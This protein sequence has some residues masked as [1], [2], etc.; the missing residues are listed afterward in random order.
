MDGFRHNQGRRDVCHV[1]GKPV[2]RYRC[3]ACDGSGRERFLL[4]FSRTCDTCHGSGQI[5]HCP[6]RLAHLEASL[7]AFTQR[8]LNRPSP[9]GRRSILGSPAATA[10]RQPCWNCKGQG[11]I[12]GKKRVPN[13][14]EFMRAIPGFETIV[15]DGL[16]TCSVCQGRGWLARRG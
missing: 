7:S 3:G 10:D 12:A 13:P 9:L 1:C 8:R 11:T 14:Q 2:Q 4:L 16:V 15:V 5:W 6:D